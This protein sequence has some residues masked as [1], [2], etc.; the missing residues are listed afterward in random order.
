MSET[1][2]PTIR[3]VDASVRSPDAA[4]R[5]GRKLLKESKLDE[6]HEIFQDLVQRNQADAFVHGAIARIKHKHGDLDGALDHLR[7]AIK[8]DPLK[9]LPYIRSA[10]IYAMRGQLNEAKE[11]LQNVIRIRAEAPV[12]YLGLGAIYQRENQPELAIQ[13]YQTA[14]QYNPRLTPARK[15]LAECLSANGRTREAMVQIAAALRVK[16]DDPEAF[17]LKGRLHLLAQQHD[18]AQRAFEHAVELTPD[19]GKARIRLGLAEAYLQDAKLAQAEQVLD[20]IPERDQSPLFH[21]LWGDLYSA[22]DMHPEALEE[23]RAAALGSGT[24]LDIEGFGAMDFLVDA[25][26]DKWALM[27]AE[28][29]TAAAGIVEQRR[30][31]QPLARSSAET[32]KRPRGPSSDRSPAR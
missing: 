10:R 16:P 8:M 30:R 31:E 25:D 12:A 13:Q 6:A 1:F 22:R 23:Y 24:D 32:G 20:G 15:R 5:K 27:A 14:L 3:R 7:I 18:E 26:A 28:A 19:G 11:A 17:A 9:P 4:V 21:K 2:K 29:R